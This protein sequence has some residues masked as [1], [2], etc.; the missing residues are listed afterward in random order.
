MTILT[1]GRPGKTQTIAF[2]ATPE[3]SADFGPQTYRVRLVATAACLVTI[4]NTD[5]ASFY[6]AANFP[7]VFIVTPGQ[8]VTVEQVSG[9]GNLFATELE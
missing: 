2:N 1:H 8:S 5:S 4:N 3:T 9:A 7:E 6:L